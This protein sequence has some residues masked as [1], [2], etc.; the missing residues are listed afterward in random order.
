[1]VWVIFADKEVVCSPG[2]PTSG[3]SPFDL[4]VEDGHVVAEALH[5]VDNP[6]VQHVLKRCDVGEQPLALGDFLC[7]VFSIG[8]A[9]YWFFRQLVWYIAA[10]VEGSVL[11]ARVAAESPQPLESEQRAPRG[12]LV[13]RSARQRLHRIRLRAKTFQVQLHEELNLKRKLMQY[14]MC[15]RRI[16][17]GQIRLSFAFDASRV[18]TRSLMLGYMA[19]PTNYGCWLP[20]QAN[21]VTQRILPAPSLQSSWKIDNSGSRFR[22]HKE[23]PWVFVYTKNSSDLWCTKNYPVFSHNT[24][25]FA[26]ELCLFQRRV[27]FNPIRFF[28]CG[29]LG[30]HVKRG[31][32]HKE[33]LWGVSG[34]SHPSA[35]EQRP[36]FLAWRRHRP[37]S[38]IGP[39]SGFGCMGQSWE[40]RLL[41]RVAWIRCAT[42]A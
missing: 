2:M 33:R 40:F 16:F 27:C 12:D 32:A 6:L 23:F 18:G 37:I 30:S 14:Y 28:V 24:K 19:D 5:M 22:A 13:P 1:M 21:G 35:S 34:A 41:G 20:P 42:L 8:V 31:S 26:Q 3:E 7:I 36:P 10:I 17:N 4:V 11:A 29:A 38:G 9:G 15:A 39:A 25:N